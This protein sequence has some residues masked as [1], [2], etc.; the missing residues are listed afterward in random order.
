M[1]ALARLRRIARHV[2]PAAA[3]PAPASALA[4]STPSAAHRCRSSPTNASSD[5]LTSA[6]AAAVADGF[7]GAVSVSVNG[8]YDWGSTID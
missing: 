5:P 1:A 6:L 3:L 4:G 7:S 2:S 8:R